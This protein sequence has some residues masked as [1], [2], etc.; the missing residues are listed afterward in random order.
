MCKEDLPP[1][2]HTIIKPHVEA[3]YG[4]NKFRCVNHS[5]ILQPIAEI[6][7]TLC[8]QTSNTVKKVAIWGDPDNERNSKQYN[9]VN[10]RGRGPSLYS[11]DFNEFFRLTMRVR[12]QDTVHLVLDEK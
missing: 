3:T 7:F 6:P 4:N 5:N 11:S 12:K 8:L 9:M 10:L 2:I 1:I